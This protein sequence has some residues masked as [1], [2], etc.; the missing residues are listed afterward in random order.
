MKKKLLYYLMILVFLMPFFYQIALSRDFNTDEPVLRETLIE[1]HPVYRDPFI[2]GLLSWFM[3]GIGQI[4]CREYTKGSIFI[5]ADLAD[6]ASLILLVSYI[7][8]KYSQSEKTIDVNWKAFE[9]GTKVLIIS[10]LTIKFGLRFYN[11]IDAIQSANEY[12]RKYMSQRDD[13]KLSLNF[14]QDSF[15][16]YYTLHFSDYP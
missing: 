1:P 5:A 8:N 7:N 11:V 2:A 4:Y 6:K 9:P 13:E 16:L 12:N 10:Y 3:M 15:S 14:D